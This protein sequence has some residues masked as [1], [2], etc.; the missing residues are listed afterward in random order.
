LSNRAPRGGRYRASIEQACRLDF[1]AFSEGSAACTFE[2]APPREQDT[3]YGDQGVRAVEEVLRALGAGEKGA[4][5]WSQKLVPGLL[6][7]LGRFA[8]IVDDGIDRV[9]FQL[10]AGPVKRR[11]RITSAFRTHVRDALVPARGPDEVRAEG[12]I[13]ECDWRR[14]SA[15]LLEPDGHKVVLNLP[16]ELDEEATSARRQRVI[17]FGTTKDGGERPSVIDVTRIELAGT[18]TVEVDSRYGGFFDNLSIEE[19]ARLQGVPESRPLED[20]RSDW[21]DGESLD[22]LL[23]DLRELR[24]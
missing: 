11:A 17:V 14:H 23:D 16:D 2:L 7:S 15:E 10:D 4:E 1:V 22:E 21:L 13:W 19:L 20:Y 18:G 5:G 12:V 3:L 8:R 9:D 6:D 24:S